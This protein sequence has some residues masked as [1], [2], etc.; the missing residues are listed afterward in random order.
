MDFLT[1]RSLTTSNCVLTFQAT[2]WTLSS[3]KN[4]SCYSKNWGQLLKKRSLRSSKTSPEKF[5]KGFHRTI[6]S[7]HKTV[8]QKRWYWP[9]KRISGVHQSVSG[10]IPESS[11]RCFVELRSLHRRPLLPVSFIVTY[12]F[13]LLI[14][15]SSPLSFTL[16][17]LSCLLTLAFTHSFFYLFFPYLFHSHWILLIYFSSRLCILIEWLCI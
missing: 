4:G 11:A 1:R 16:H 7:R 14:Y 3:T 8:Q 17:S 12:A 2:I 6:F 10:S 9:L 15:L 13:F 5:S